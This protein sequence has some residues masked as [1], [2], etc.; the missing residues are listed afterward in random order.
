MFKSQYDNYYVSLD[1]VF[2]MEF[3]RNPYIITIDKII[4]SK[5]GFIYVS[6]ETVIDT[7]ASSDQHIRLKSTKN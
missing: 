1:Q 4:G 2:V 7:F 6:R 3:K 5:E